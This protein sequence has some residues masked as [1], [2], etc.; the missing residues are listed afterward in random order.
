L[1]RIQLGTLCSA[2]GRSRQ[3]AQPRQVVPLSGQATPP[4]F[5]IHLLRTAQ[6]DIPSKF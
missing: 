3:S 1:L 4:K 5:D 6:V 2:S